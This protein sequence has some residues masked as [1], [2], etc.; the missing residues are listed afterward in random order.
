MKSGGA[1]GADPSQMLNDPDMMKAAEEM[2]KSLGVSQFTVCATS[3]LIVGTWG[4]IS[5]IL[6]ALNPFLTSLS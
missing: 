3:R 6:K 5:R 4:S 2:M 1:D